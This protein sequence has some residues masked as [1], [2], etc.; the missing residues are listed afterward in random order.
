VHDLGS[1][2][3]SAKI[4]VFSDVMPCRVVNSYRRFERTTTLLKDVTIFQSTQHNIPEDLTL[5]TSLHIIHTVYTQ[6]FN[7]YR[8]HYSHLRSSNCSYNMVDGTT[9]QIL[10]SGISPMTVTRLCA[11][12]DT[13]TCH[14]LI[15]H[16]HSL[17]F[18]CRW[19]LPLGSL[20]SNTVCLRTD[21]TLFKYG[22]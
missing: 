13:A 18:S 19:T 15:A 5:P 21:S 6:I 3:G 22:A 8:P 14:F 4:Q 17:P 10:S 7:E 2:S 11:A 12:T 16:G 20:N 1:H 9:P